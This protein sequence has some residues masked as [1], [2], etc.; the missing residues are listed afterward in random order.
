MRDKLHHNVTVAIFFAIVSTALRTVYVGSCPLF[1][2]NVLCPLVKDVLPQATRKKPVET[3]S[4]PLGHC[5]PRLDSRRRHSF[6]IEGRRSKRNYETREW[7]TSNR[8]AAALAWDANALGGAI[9]R[10]DLTDEDGQA[11]LVNYR[12]SGRYLIVDRLF[13]KAE[14]RLGAKRRQVRVKITNRAWGRS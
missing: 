4:G 5:G 11:E 7:R 13:E 3:T 6:F 9:G 12:V 1:L 14:L 2:A 8:L 10:H